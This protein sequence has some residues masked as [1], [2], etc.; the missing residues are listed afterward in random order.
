MRIRRE[1]PEYAAMMRRMLA[2]WTR[3]AEDVQNLRPGQQIGEIGWVAV[4]PQAIAPVIAL[5][6]DT[7]PDDVTTLSG[8]LH[9]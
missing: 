6:T 3:R 8:G 7:V 2:A 1:N 9:S 5:M 4:T